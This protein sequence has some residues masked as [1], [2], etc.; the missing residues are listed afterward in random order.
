MDRVK[1]IL[2]GSGFFAA[3]YAASHPDSL[4][5]E[6]GQLADAAFFPSMEGFLQVPPTAKS[7]A[8]GETARRL[9]AAGFYQGNS[10]DPT[11]TEPVLSASMAANGANVLFSTVVTG[12][13]RDEDG[14]RVA[15]FTPDGE[16][17]YHAGRVIDTRVPSDGHLYRVLLGGIKEEI[18]DGTS[19]D[20]IPYSV[21]SGLP[22]ERAVL[23]LCF[24][25]DVSPADGR[26]AAVRALEA[27][28]PEGGQ[29]LTMALICAKENYP[30][31]A[32]TR[33][34]FVRLDERFFFDP[35]TAYET[36]VTIR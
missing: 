24:P 8:G 3:G 30:A 5:L 12:I 15:V 18:P 27:C 14:F 19:P 31:P 23:T 25:T 1:T 17:A 7:R 22:G 34:G 11:K 36:G 28:M 4:I 33:E 6:A 29:V 26:L 9:R 13:E 32:W 10:N 21:L 2:L 16:R 20:G 35:L